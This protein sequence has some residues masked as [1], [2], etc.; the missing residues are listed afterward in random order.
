[1]LVLPGIDVLLRERLDLVANRR[2][3]LISN[4]SG[5]THDLT[6]SVD[7]LQRAPNVQLTAL[8]APEHG[9][10]TLV[11]DGAAVESSVDLHTG[12]S[13][14]SLYGEVRRPTTE[15]LTGLDVLIFDIQSVGVRFYTYITTLLYAMQAV[16]EQGLAFIVCDR[17]N[18]IGG[19]IVEGPVLE[20]GFESFVGPGRLPTRHG[21]TV[22]ELARLYNEAWDVGCD[23]TVIPCAGWQRAMWFDDTGLPWIP[24]SP[25]MP[26]PATALVYPGTCLIE[27]TN[28]SEGR[29]T[30]LPF[31]YI[32]A[33]WID[34]WRLADAL[35]RLDL[36]G[37]RFRPA[38]FRPT[39]DKWAGRL[40]GGVQL[41]VVDRRAFRPVTVG[42]HLIATVR[43]LYPDRFAWREGGE[44][45]GH[46]TIDLLTGT[47]KVRWALESGV[48]VADLAASWADGLDQ[49]VR[50]SH[51]YFLYR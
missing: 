4:V 14:Y 15:T 30:A 19:E 34:G 50:A 13:V 6:S 11:A 26:W 37:A 21:M 29:G 16:A 40:C 41:H 46:I 51:P 44:E 45:G 47:D 7:A 28:L 49:F 48:S 35:N 39:A 20:R 36:P 38:S 42:L 17:P 3:G 27:G 31:H 9:F 24:P 5:V 25:A 33:P 1:M 2:V 8:F 10:Y 32:G 22:G 12:L 23:L 18:P 43:S